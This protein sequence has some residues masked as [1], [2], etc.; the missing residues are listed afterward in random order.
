MDVLYYLARRDGHDDTEDPER[1]DEGCRVEGEEMPGARVAPAD[2]DGT[3][4]D[5]R[6]PL[7]RPR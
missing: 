2:D 4:Q 5:S 1:R 7:G 3:L 6:R